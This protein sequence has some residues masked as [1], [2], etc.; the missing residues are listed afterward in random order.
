[1][2]EIVLSPDESLARLGVTEMDRVLANQIRKFAGWAN[3]KNYP[4]TNDEVILTAIRA[5]QMGVHPLNDK[6]FN[7]YKDSHGIHLD[8][9][10]SLIAKYVT[11]ARAIRH[12]NPRYYR[13]TA[14]ELEAEGLNQNFVAY[15]ATFILM[16]DLQH[17]YD[18]MDRIPEELAYRT[19]AKSGIGSA[20]KAKWDNQYFAPNGRSKA[21]KVQKRALKDAYVKAFGYPSPAEAAALQAASGWVAPSESDLEL[22]ALN[23]DY[24]PNIVALAQNEAVVRAALENPQTDEERAETHAALWGDEAPIVD[25]PVTAPPAEPAP[26]EQP[27]ESL[28]PDDA[29]KAAMNSKPFASA[30]DA[31]KWGYDSGVFK[32]YQHAENAY[33]KVR[34]EKAPSSSGEMWT[35][36]RV[37]VT[38]RIHAKL[39]RDELSGFSDDEKRE[40]LNDTLAPM[41]LAQGVPLPTIQNAA[42]TDPAIVGLESA[43]K[44]Y[45]EK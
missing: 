21:W 17:Y 9:H 24:T 38:N 14:E 42:D 6:A 13:L 22:G 7:A 20:P 40:W 12:T 4:M 43:L 41:A 3:S 37:D 27:A 32:V 33:E 44:A 28:W 5:R 45:A 8:Y 11:K 26:A 16:D 36:W 31:I 39:E 30:Q 34:S 19:I 10:Y 1:M 15:Y 18:L 29:I 23:T 35:L 2:N 25:V